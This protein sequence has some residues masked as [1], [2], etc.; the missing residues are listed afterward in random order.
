MSTLA[1]I[2]H[3]YGTA[4]L[5]KYDKPYGKKTLNTRD[6]GVKRLDGTHE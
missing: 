4:Y 1:D 6:S 5:D 2:V 3:E